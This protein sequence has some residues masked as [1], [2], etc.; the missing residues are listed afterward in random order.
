MVIEPV[1]WKANAADLKA[2]NPSSENNAFD[3][4]LRE[5]I[6]WVLFSWIVSNFVLLPLSIFLSEFLCRKVNV[7]IINWGKGG[8]F[9]WTRGQVLNLNSKR[10]CY[11]TVPR[12]HSVYVDSLQFFPGL[13]FVHLESIA[14]N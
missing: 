9:P 11:K 10:K 3:Y 14:W 13:S 8:V 5:Q 6:Q 2:P 1:R 4:T 12:L 7:D